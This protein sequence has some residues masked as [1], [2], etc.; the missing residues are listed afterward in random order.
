MSQNFIQVNGKHF[1]K[2][3]TPYYFLGANFWY[4]MNLAS[5]GLGGDR[6]RLLREL[7][8]LQDLG[9]NNLRIMA[10]SEG[11]D[12][13]PWRMKPALMSAPNIYNSDL[14][15][16]LD[17]LLVEMG[18]RN[19]H[20]VLCLSNFWA[21]S[22]GMAQYVN[23]ATNKPIPYHHPVDGGWAKYSFY[24]SKFYK[25]KKAKELYWKHVERIVNRKNSITKQLYKDDPTI[26]AW[27]L[28]N[29]PRGMFRP[30]KY[31]QWIKETAALIK[32]HDPN[33]LVSIGS[34]GKT[35]FPIGNAPY[36]DHLDEN[37]DYL[38]F[39]IWIQNWQW[40]DPTQAKKTYP[41]A[42][43]KA[44]KYLEKHLGF[45]EKLNK[46]IVLEEFGIARDDDDHSATAPTN[47]RDQYYQMMFELIYEKAKSGYAMAGCNFWAWGGEGRPTAPKAIWKAGDDFIGDPPHEFQGWYS[48]YEKDES[49]L[50]LIKKY[51]D[52]FL[53]LGEERS[54]S[55]NPI[56]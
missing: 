4:G 18:K 29:E 27:Q 26:M 1:E 15:E 39:H 2:A 36:K 56:K 23:W 32:S 46:P 40:Y 21:W 14:L 48:V 38:T 7:D 20:A 6:A 10:A 41:K 53:D 52:L 11:P 24:T 35:P 12:A 33:H 55:L 8:R 3:G 51:T 50:H 37:I 13:E 34:E 47:W 44:K 42:Y 17:F 30:R 19:I 22:G 9:I 45:A 25:L 49:T 16:G 5:E 43:A 54:T 31:R 28:A